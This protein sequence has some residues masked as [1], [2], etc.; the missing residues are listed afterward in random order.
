MFR[1]LFITLLFISG[2]ALANDTTRLLYNPRANV[3]KDLA[4]IFVKARQDGKRVLLQIGNNRCVWCYRL[5]SFIHRDSALKK[6][7][8]ENYITYHLNY[9]PENQNLTYMKK[10]GDPQRFGF[11]VLVVLNEN[12]DKLHIQNSGLLAKGNGYDELKVKEFLL[13]WT[14]PTNKEFQ[15]KL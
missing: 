5:N 4:E 8:D 1:L 9:S 14:P 12:G 3:E 2:S 13:Q 6:I 15:N 10:L 7:L 11:P